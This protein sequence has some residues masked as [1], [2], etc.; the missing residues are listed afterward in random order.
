MVE[1]AAPPDVSFIDLSIAWTSV[2]AAPSTQAAYVRSIVIMLWPCCL[3]TQRRFL[4]TIRFQLT[5]E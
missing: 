3:A 5:E 4:P 2:S 1:R